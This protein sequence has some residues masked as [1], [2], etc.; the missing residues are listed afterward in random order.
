[1]KNP[2]KWIKYKTWFLF[3]LPY[4]IR[5]KG[6]KKGM[7]L[8]VKS[9]R[10]MYH[11]L[12][13]NKQLHLTGIDLWEV[14]EG[15]AYTKNDKNEAKCRKKLKRFENRCSLIKG[16]AMALSQEAEDYSYDFI[17]YDLQC[18]PMMNSHQKMLEKWIPKIKK[19]G[20]LIGRDFRAFR[21]VFYNMGYQECD[22]LPCK[23][24]NKTSTRIEYIS[25]T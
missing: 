1:M 5:E 2:V 17:Y 11:L 23:F 12:R 25:I 22:I 13:V 15:G 18:K 24:K 9:G 3:D 21:E 6:Y 19:G 16:N 7:E 8:G 20:V 4:F 10:S 14:I